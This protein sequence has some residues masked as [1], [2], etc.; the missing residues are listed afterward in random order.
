MVKSLLDPVDV[1]SQEVI[2]TANVLDNDGSS[3]G[4]YTLDLIV[5]PKL[6]SEI[7]QLPTLE[8]KR[9][10]RDLGSGKV[11]QIYVLVAEDEYVIYFRSATNFTET[12]RVVSSISMYKSVIDEKTRI[13]RYAAQSWKS[14]QGNTL[15]KDLIEFK[16]VFPESVPFELPKDKATRH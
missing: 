15:Y 4:S 6:T 10:L 1:T 5:P 16:D 8:P 14:L 9:F 12:E 11:K 3:V 13:E 7:T 2:E